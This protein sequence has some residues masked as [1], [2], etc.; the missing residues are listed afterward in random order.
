M[1]KSN[2]NLFR[3][4]VEALG[5]RLVPAVTLFNGD[6]IV[7]VG[8]G[9]D[10]VTVTRSLTRYTV[11]E[12]GVKT[13]FS[14]FAVFGGDVF[15]NGNGGNDTFENKTSLR[16]TA[17]GGAGNDVLI[18]GSGKDYLVG[19]LGQDFLYGMGGDD[20][21]W[22]GTDLVGKDDGINYVYG[23]AGNDIVRGGTHGFGGR[24]D[25]LYG[26]AG[27]D[28]LLGLGDNDFLDGGALDA[29]RDTLH[30]GDGADD[31]TG[32]AGNDLLAGNGGRD[33]LVGGTGSD[34]LYG[35]EGNDRLLGGSGYDVLYG[36]AGNDHLDAGSGV[37]LELNRLD[38]GTGSDTLVGG[39]GRDHLTGGDGL[40]FL[41]GNAGPDV[42]DGGDD[43]FADYLSGGAGN[44]RFQVELFNVNRNR[45]NPVDLAPGDRFFD[46]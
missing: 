8:D 25:E 17:R 12:N 23:G 7:S 20:E 19:D 28:E 10:Q 37:Y 35:G 46:L 22:G 16:A 15:F 27:N 2:S 31:L 45:D 9:D 32:G 34:T 11:T 40:D 41:Y 39:S 43:G 13:S 42:L 33:T 36:E 6:L 18:G 24:G 21:T 3:P 44:D 1:R 5:D 14:R 26:E 4:T 38:G 29:G 30:G